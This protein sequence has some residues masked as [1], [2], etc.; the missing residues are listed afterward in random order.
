MRL[1]HSE[2]LRHTSFETKAN[3]NHG[4]CQIL[5]HV[6]YIQEQTHSKNIRN[7]CSPNNIAYTEQH[8]TTAASLTSQEIQMI[9]S[10]IYI[11]PT[12]SCVH[13]DSLW[14]KSERYDV[15][16]TQWRYCGVRN[17]MQARE[18]GRWWHMVSLR[19]HVTPTKLTCVRYDDTRTRTMSGKN[20][21]GVT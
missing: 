16:I 4:R 18:D 10:S 13:M 9:T 14:S 11:N 3:L 6:R 1:Q 5:S 19:P 8:R 15:D 12:Q 7:I 2:I 20:R 17:V 21:R